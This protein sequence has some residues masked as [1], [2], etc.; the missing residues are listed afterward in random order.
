MIELCWR[1]RRLWYYPTW[2]YSI[3]IFVSF[4]MMWFVT[5]SSFRLLDSH[6]L[7]LI[8]WKGEIESFKFS[9]CWPRWWWSTG[10]E[11]RRK[12]EN[13]F[14]I[15]F[16]HLNV[17]TTFFLCRKSFRRRQKGREANGNAGR[18]T[19]F[20]RGLCIWKANQAECA[21]REGNKQQSSRQYNER[22]SFKRH[23]RV[24]R[25]TFTRCKSS[26]RP[27]LTSVV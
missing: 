27:R 2:I 16:L 1:E 14:G 11:S 21:I 26:S 10:W 3:R 22:R 6:W 24:V 18:L 19:D 17:L 8:I 13:T 23:G 4:P 9:F 15:R 5:K 25:E 12:M 20:V 7:W